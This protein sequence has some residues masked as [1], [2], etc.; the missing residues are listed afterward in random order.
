MLV[1]IYRTVLRPIREDSKLNTTVYAFNASQFP[2]SY[3]IVFVLSSMM[4]FKIIGSLSMSF[5]FATD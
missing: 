3:W 4:A 1:H 2:L 5:I